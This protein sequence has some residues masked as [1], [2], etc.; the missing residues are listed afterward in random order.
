M[1]MTPQLNDVLLVLRAHE[2]E[3]RRKGVA[4]LAV[5]GSLARGQSTPASDI[6]VMVDLDPDNIPSL[7]TY[8]GIARELEAWLGRP[9]DLAVRTRLKRFVRPI[10]EAEAI[11][12]F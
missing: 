9:V 4:S 6:D 12:A 7:F 2:E 5:F 10:A 3:L 11:Y 8:L 1:D